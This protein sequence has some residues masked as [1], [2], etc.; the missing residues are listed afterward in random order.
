M[1]DQLGQCRAYLI[2]RNGVETASL[3]TIAR[4]AGFGE[5]ESLSARGH[6]EREDGPRVNFFIVHRHLKSSVMA[7]VIR[8]IRLSSDDQIRFA[9]VILFA[10]DGPFETYLHYVYMGFDD[11]IT[12]PDKQPVLV[13]RLTGQLL[14][15]Q[16]YF[17][18]REYFGPD[19]RRMEA[20][21]ETDSRRLPDPHSHTR[22]TFV[23]VPGAGINI[24]KTE[25]F[26]RPEIANAALLRAPLP[27]HGA[28]R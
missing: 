3:T 25:I 2:A 8:S 24:V 10:E 17:Q 7:G 26:A 11:I 14:S 13:Q 6:R 22:Y 1:A 20:P 12:L 27:G 28:L 4:R 9:P 16:T 15:E 23:R 5:V 21:W 18:T 19:R